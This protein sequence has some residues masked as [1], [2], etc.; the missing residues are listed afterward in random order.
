MLWSNFSKD[1]YCVAAIR[2]SNG[3]ITGEWLHDERLLYSGENRPYDGGHGMIF[4]ALNGYQYLSIHSP[5]GAVGNP[6]EKPIF[7]RIEGKDGV[8][9]TGTIDLYEQESR[10]AIL[11][12]VSLEN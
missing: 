11:S 1:G 9:Y 4:T 5:N 12:M 2:S 3:K 6:N 10:G 7:Y 8:I